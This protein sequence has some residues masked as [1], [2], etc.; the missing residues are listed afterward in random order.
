MFISYS[1]LN[2]NKLNNMGI[3]LK[4]ICD[5]RENREII[6]SEEVRKNN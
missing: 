5:C 4:N 6:I 3:Q 1:F 2:S